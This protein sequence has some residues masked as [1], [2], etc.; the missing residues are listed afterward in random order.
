MPSH[1]TLT[2]CQV[3]S[4]A[5]LYQQIGAQIPADEAF[6]HNLDGLYDLL[7][8]NLAGPVQLN[9][10][11]FTQASQHLNPHELSAIENLLH[12]ISSERADF[13]LQLK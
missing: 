6:G 5:E 9:W 3:H 4:L 11:D 10:P 8:N 1:T 13:S 12:E 2:L 7:A